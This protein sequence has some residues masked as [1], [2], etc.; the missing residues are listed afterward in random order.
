MPVSTLRLPDCELKE[1]FRLTPAQREALARA[2]LAHGSRKGLRAFLDQHEQE[3]NLARVAEELMGRLEESGERA[4]IDLERDDKLAE[5]VHSF[6]ERAGKLKRQQALLASELE[7]FDP[8]TGALVES[9]LIKRL[10]EPRRLRWWQRWLAWLAR[11]WRR[12]LAWL[13]RL[14]RR[15]G[16]PARSRSRLPS[17]LVLG[18]RTVLV[19]A[20][21]DQALQDP[22]LTMW[23]GREAAGE[24]APSPLRQWW[25][26]NFTPESYR[27]QAEEA[28]QRELNRVRAGAARTK[29]EKR[30]EL[31]GL[32]LEGDRLRE[33]Q[34][35]GEVELERQHQRRLSRHEEERQ[36]RS[37]EALRE[38]VARQALI[39]G[40]VEAR[41]PADPTDPS[42]G[43]FVVSES[44]IATLGTRLFDE[45]IGELTVP[46]P[47]TGLSSE[48]TGTYQRRPLMS[49]YETSRLDLVASVV[50]ARLAHPG[51]RSLLD[52]DL[53]VHAEERLASIHAVVCVDISGSMADNRR[54]E[55]AKRA[56]LALYGAVKAER[57]ANRVDFVALGTTARRVNL[58]ELWELE[59][60]GFTNTA[61]AITL[62]QVLLEEGRA[63][64]RLLYLVTDGL[65]EAHT[66]DAGE[67]V[68]GDL[69]RAM[70]QARGALEG[71]ARMSNT[72]VGFLL[73]EPEEELFVTAARELA[74]AG[75]G[76]LLV[77][78]PQ[79]LARDLVV[80]F[81][82]TSL[83]D[84]PGGEGQPEAD[85][86][87]VNHREE[88]GRDKR[89][90]QMDVR[91][92]PQ[93]E[94]GRR[95]PRALSA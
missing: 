43:S 8:L 22:E 62:G 64:R 70:E 15:K 90:G 48:D 41:D 86:A 47:L 57:E 31:K 3:A 21:L 23:L 11:G 51:H 73:L 37:R 74:A 59:S 1:P 78:D 53:V 65:P 85:S 52:G 17:S 49:H 27:H 69:E 68:A 13:K 81:L 10:V 16:K 80:D 79:S 58:R 35:L 82:E 71:V 39:A 95:R 4:A 63:D 60:R 91:D 89:Q 45:L 26:R 66:T 92:D 44:L 50:N 55:A 88:G 56:A 5:L 72:K 25:R 18:G 12:L 2:L 32:D 20:T 7:R 40:L 87:I 9:D 29:R 28:L 19:E 42:V 34:R 76:R 36:A 38:Q 6:Q 30:R 46:G 54:L 83:D 67:P 24:R 84:G 77:T 61:A 93:K 75:Q 14:F 94:A 33:R